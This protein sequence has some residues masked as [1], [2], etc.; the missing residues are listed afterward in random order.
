MSIAVKND[1]IL[2]DKLKNEIKEKNSGR[3]NARLSQQLTLKY[4]NE[5]EK[6]GKKP[7]KGPKRKNNKL[8]KWTNEQWQYIKPN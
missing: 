8:T 2:W 4:I 3:W 5:M 1:P 6:L 7:F